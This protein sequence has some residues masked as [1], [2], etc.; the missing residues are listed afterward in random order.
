MACAFIQSPCNHCHPVS[1]HVL[2]SSLA[3]A[4]A[5]VTEVT[6]VAVESSRLLAFSLPASSVVLSSR[7]AVS[8]LASSLGF[9]AAHR[10]VGLW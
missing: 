1:W 9:L 6:V 10:D 8:I 2:A 7:L 5:V 4:D 3:A